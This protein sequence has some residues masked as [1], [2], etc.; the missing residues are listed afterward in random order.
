VIVFFVAALLTLAVGSR[1][2]AQTQP[3]SHVVGQLQLHQLTSRVFGN[4]RVIR[5]LLPHEY[6]APAHSTTRYSVLYLNDGQNLF[7]AA[8][9]TFNL[10]EWQ[11]DE[12]V[13]RLTSAGVVPPLIVVGIDHAGRGERAHE[14]LPYP[15]AFLRPPDP[16]PVGDRYPAFVIDE[17]MPFVD[18]H[19]RTV[20]DAAHRAIGGSSYGALA[21]LFTAI[22]R[23][24]V[25]GRLLLE[26]PSLYVNDGRVIHQAASARE[27]P[28]RIYLG[29]GTNESGT[30]TCNESGDNNEA[31][32]DVRRLAAALAHRL[33]KDAIRVSV[34]PCGRHDEAAWARRLPEALRFL[35][36]Q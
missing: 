28:T 26:S 34:E 15:D 24:G 13:H 8:T 16:H 3:A 7:D 23:P 10:M 30:A 19:Y 36:A 33:R 18:G 21:A 22:A 25:F 35:Y 4:T 12:T 6:D 29:V 5:V 14:Y 1:A 11:V 17:V 2:L 20:R 31:V 32:V 27:L 9:S